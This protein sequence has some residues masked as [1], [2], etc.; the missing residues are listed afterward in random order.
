VRIETVR[1]KVKK[2][3]RV[4]KK[5]IAARFKQLHAA[6]DIPPNRVISGLRRMLATDAGDAGESDDE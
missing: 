1:A 4:T 2:A 6:S 5:A 3:K